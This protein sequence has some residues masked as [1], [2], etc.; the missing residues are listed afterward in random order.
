MGHLA[1]SKKMYPPLVG[2]EGQT[3]VQGSPGIFEEN[4]SSIARD[5]KVFHEVKNL[6]GLI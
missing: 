2:H 1:F 4:I 3:I 6:S 5:L